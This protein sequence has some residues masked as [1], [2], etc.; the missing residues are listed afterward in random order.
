MAGLVP[1]IH[2][3]QGFDEAR[4]GCQESQTSLRSLRKS[5]LLWPGMTVERFV[6]V[7]LLMDLATWR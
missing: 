4:R 5:R 6:F 3:L 2:V 7:L 1:V